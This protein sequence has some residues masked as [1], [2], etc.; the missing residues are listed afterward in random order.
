MLW[1]YYYQIALAI[2][3][4]SPVELLLFDHSPSKIEPNVYQEPNIRIKPT[5]PRLQGKTV[6][7]S[8]SA[9]IPNT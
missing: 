4:F 2:L 8:A 7:R 6:S 5:T 3:F 9:S 1:S